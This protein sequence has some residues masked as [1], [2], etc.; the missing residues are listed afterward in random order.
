ME[1]YFD[2]LANSAASAQVGGVAP[3]RNGLPA[4]DS[5]AGPFQFG[6]NSVPN[7]FHIGYTSVS[8]RL[9]ARAGWEV[10]AAAVG[11]GDG[12]ASANQRSHSSSVNLSLHETL[13][14]PLLRE[15]RGPTPW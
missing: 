15:R 7:R 1:A 14:P 13:L 8:H 2:P 9:G 4:C 10:T 6:Y 5:G 12:R 11:C 3:V